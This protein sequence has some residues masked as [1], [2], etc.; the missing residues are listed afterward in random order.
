MNPS[1]TGPPGSDQPPRIFRVKKR[2]SGVKGL[3]GITGGGLPEGRIVGIMGGPGSGKTIL[4]LQVLVNRLRVYDE[5][6]IF[7]SFEE[8]LPHIRANM[9]SFDWNLR[10]IA[11]D[12]LCL[13]DAQMA[14]ETVRMGAFDLSGLLATLAAAKAKIGARNIVF[15]GLDALLSGL[16]DHQ[17][18]RQELR[19]LAAWIQQENI[20]GILTVKAAGPNIRDQIREDYLQYMLDCVISLEAKLFGTSLSRTLRVLKY[21]G[22]GFA[23]NPFP[24]IISTSGV[25]IVSSDGMRLER[26]NIEGR[27]ST[28]I[29]EL[30][31]LMQ[32]GY[33]TGD[34]ILISGVPGT[35]KTSLASTFVAAA[36]AR[37]E[38]SLYVSFDESMSQLMLKMRSIGI[39]LQSHIE[40]RLLQIAAFQSTARSP[41]DLF[42]SLRDLIAAHQP[43]IV[44][45]D[46]VSALIRLSYPY[47]K[48][49]AD[50]L[51][52]MMKSLGITT[53]YTSLLSP[54]GHDSEGTVSHLST[55]VDTWIQLSYHARGGERNRA[56]TIIKSRGTAHSNQVRELRLDRTGL[57]LVDIYLAEGEVLMGTARLEKEAADER[58]KTLRRIEFDEH[59]F[60]MQR[61]LGELELR[62]KAASQELEWKRQ[63][64]LLD[65]E[66]RREQLSG[67]IE[68][69][70]NR[71]AARSSEVELAAS[72]V[73]TQ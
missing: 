12:R 67:E 56:L 40:S 33:P 48:M 61:T 52:D 51:F 53:L 41:E 9:D 54:D 66:R 2:L 35:A 45:I 57:H 49:I 22:S 25:E 3:D 11:D 44:V 69:L 18:E 37:G 13:L 8:S 50:T 65:D 36:C 4:S 1:H 58:Q 38:K 14:P 19:R 72:G 46:P 34:G 28:G 31:V 6:S 63:E 43:T 7:V 15:D 60:V 47:A 68:N 17:T 55:V 16:A 73:M 64:L 5:A 30:D 59:R 21:R 71:R 27:V 10:E 23:A 62:A 39:D 20:S 24:A 70:E 29:A 26:A 32:G 42:L